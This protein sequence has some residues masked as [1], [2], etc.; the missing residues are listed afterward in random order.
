MYS[1]KA[2][3]ELNETIDKQNN[4]ANFRGMNS[5][6]IAYK[7]YAS[8]KT[9]Y[10]KSQENV[11]TL[12]E[13]L[14][15]KT[16][17]NNYIDK[18][19]K[20]RASELKNTLQ[21][22]ELIGE[23]IEVYFELDEEIEN[24]L[25]SIEIE[26]CSRQHPVTPLPIYAEQFRQRWAHLKRIKPFTNRLCSFI[27]EYV[28]NT[29]FGKKT[30]VCADAKQSI[31]ET[32]SFK[33]ASKKHNL[34]ALFSKYKIKDSNDFQKFITGLNITFAYL[35]NQLSGMRS[36]ELR[37]LQYGC[38]IPAS[39]TRPPLLRGYTSKKNNGIDCM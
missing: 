18:M 10:N 4:F 9:L 28:S 5:A 29:Y 21:T 15:C 6:K 20:S 22:I 38:Y 34:N 33:K 1:K 11:N 7:H 12:E 16:K 24:K 35:L 26:Y 17:L 36:G 31:K 14:L 39:K 2:I 32:V 19:S 8:L 37:K 27:E 13:I 23:G 3:M 30:T 25:I